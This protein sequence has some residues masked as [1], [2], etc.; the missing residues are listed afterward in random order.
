VSAALDGY[1][2]AVAVSTAAFAALVVLLSQRL[3]APELELMR[4][5]GATRGAAAAVVGG[6][7]AIIALAAVTIT[8]LA[9]TL[10]LR[11]IGALVT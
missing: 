4:R 1:F 3:R 11:W 6:E 8:V 9:V 10:A 5:I 7:L 2:A